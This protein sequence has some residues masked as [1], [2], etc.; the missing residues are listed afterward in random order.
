M[1]LILKKIYY[2]IKLALFPTEHDKEVKRWYLND[3][4]ETIR[5]DYDLD[6]NSLVI[7]L[8]GYKGQWASDI[9]SKFNCHIL[10]FEPVKVFSERISQRF[11]KNPNIK[12]FCMA[13]GAS[14]RQETIFLGNDGTSLY[15][16][17]SEK[18][19]IQFQDVAKI[20]ID[21]N[22]QNVDLLKVN[23]EGGEYELLPR[24]IESGLITKIK[25]IQVQFHNITP[26]SE[27]N[28]GIIQQKLS[29]THRPTYQYKFVWENWVRIDE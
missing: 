15:G 12:V 19:L 28:M 25:N 3:P 24:L 11:S 5:L 14:S 4:E 18:E 26:G 8:G 23:I 7:D 22:I 13:L 6:S 16:N 21:Q 9:Y 10:I 17:S 2:R 27:M 20:F 29:Q 1:N